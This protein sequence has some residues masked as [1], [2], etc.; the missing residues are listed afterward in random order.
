MYERPDVPK[1]SPNRNKVAA[2]V[3]VLIAVA[4]FVLVSAL[5]RLANV[6]SALGSSDV[7]QTLSSASSSLGDAQALAEASGATVTGD[8]VETVLF[9]VLDGSDSSR[10]VATFLAAIDSTRGM[11]KL[12]FL[13][14]DALLTSAD[15][16]TSIA[17]TYAADGL[18]GLATSLTQEAAIPVSHAI[19][20]TQDGWNAFLDTA[21]QGGSA[22]KANAAT[23]VGGIVS[24]DLDA[25]GLL[26]IAQRAVSLG[27]GTS[28]IVDAPVLEDGSLDA[29]GLARLAGLLA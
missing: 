27:V 6:N 15:G 24:S 8:E 9:V 22:L 25:T 29:A 26:D 10:C 4:A 17:D 28:D 13:P 3:L 18:E 2:C 5:W 21:R 12:I 7:E 11:A 20:M 23:L 19:V 16:L 14:Q 1:S